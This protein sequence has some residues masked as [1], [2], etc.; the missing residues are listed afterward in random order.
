MK[1][2][3]IYIFALLI[4][5]GCD[6][7]FEF[8][9]EEFL[10]EYDL[11]TQPMLAVEAMI[12]E[13]DT[14]QVVR[15]TTTK[16]ISG[17][18]KSPVVKDAV[19][20]VTGGGT[21][22]VYEYVDSLEAF[23]ARFAGVPDMEY[24]LQINW[25]GKAYEA[26]ETMANLQRF[27]IDSIEIRV[28]LFDLFHR[29]F[30]DPGAPFRDLRNEEILIRAN[31]EYTVQ[32]TMVGGKIFEHHVVYINPLNGE[33]LTEYKYGDLSEFWFGGEPYVIN[34]ASEDAAMNVYKV[35]LYAKESQVENNYY[36]FDIKRE[37]RSWLQPGQIIIAD[38]FAVGENIDGIEF[39]GF[40]VEGDEVEFV[41]YGISRQAYNY[42]LSLQSLLNT[43]GG[44]FG[45]I[46]GNPPTNIFDEDG[47]P[48]LGYFEVNK[49]ARVKKIVLSE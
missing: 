7:F 5:T 8:G 43:D 32:D 4:L 40:F 37:G 17:G 33:V 46:P 44:S 28:A 23:A 22:Y 30:F 3:A 21:S 9:G 15:L 6:R 19:V 2:Y 47:N 12:T 16:S 31:P 45:S 42:Y 20:E 24:H 14:I 18:E 11:K 25:N 39:P 38:D 10:D 41:M 26:R 13:E 29:R 34:A 49:I 36:R 1:K 35:F 27:E 48:G